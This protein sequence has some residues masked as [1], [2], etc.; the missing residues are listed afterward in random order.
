MN[1][2][3]S[4]VLLNLRIKINTVYK[5]FVNCLASSRKPVFRVGKAHLVELVVL[6]WTVI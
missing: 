3:E 6:D 2:H 5:D 1:K 4:L